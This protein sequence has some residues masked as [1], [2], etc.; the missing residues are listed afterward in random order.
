VGGVVDINGQMAGPDML[1]LWIRMWWKRGEFLA[2]KMIDRSAPPE[3]PESPVRM[4]LHNLH[5]RRLA[6]PS[7]KLSDK[8]ITM[9]VRRT[10]TGKP[11]TYYIDDTPQNE[12]L[13]TSS[14]QFRAIAA[15]K[16][17]H[18]FQ[19]E[20]PGQARGIPVL[21]SVLQAV[22]DIRDYDYEV[23]QAARLAADW[24]VALSTDH[25]SAQVAQITASET[26]KIQPGSYQVMPPGWKPTALTP[27]RPQSHCAPTPSDRSSRA[28][29]MSCLRLT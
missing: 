26:E 14:R 18:V 19:I 8:S 17:L 10:K 23:L 13:S 20:E 7:D 24:A 1:K 27:P 6:T 28:N 11:L 3:P 21:Q 2:R 29:H 4:R 16:M 12:T 22:A 9:G 15:N 25:P 5:P